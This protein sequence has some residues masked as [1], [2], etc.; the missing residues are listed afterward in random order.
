M[1]VALV[2][3]VSSGIGRATAIRLA[4]AGFRTFG[5][6]RA[7]A[8]P[9]PNV[10]L[11]PLDVRDSA[12]AETC[13]ATV[14]ERA[15]RIDVVV[16]NAGTALIGAAEETSIEEAKALFETNVFGVM[17]LSRAV[18]PA[19]R[20]QRFGRII[21]IGSVVGFLPSPFMSIYAATKH[22][23]EGYSE[24]LDHEVRLFGVRVIVIEPGFTRTNLSRRSP[25]ATERRTDYRAD[26]DTVAAHIE[27]NIERGADPAVIADVVLRAATA[28][29]PALHYQ[30]GARARLLRILRSLA[31]S[32]ILDRGIRKTFGLGVAP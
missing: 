21:N 16:N 3:G 15:G 1:K 25:A 30:A 27:E 19:M 4:E 2:T 11:V 9:I 13:V 22:A 10:E 28:L 20:S 6:V 12:A 17:R 24:S 8:A 31:P 18:L 23:I 29:T 7:D 14:L 32:F 26:R 5:T